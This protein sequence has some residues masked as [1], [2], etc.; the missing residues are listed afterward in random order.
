MDFTRLVE[1]KIK[2][3]I[4][5]GDFENLEGKGEPLK[6][7]D[8]SHVPEEL[9]TSYKILKNSGYLPEEMML[10]KNIAELED[11]LSV[12]EGK[13]EKEQ[14][15][16]KISEKLLRFNLLMEKRKLSHSRAFK[17]Y[18]SKIHNRLF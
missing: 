18:Q 12:C 9:R 6:L 14:L 10:K 5:D 17:Q 1:E 7:E 3:S 16:E 15:E 13:E 2:K 11:L 4:A 8:L